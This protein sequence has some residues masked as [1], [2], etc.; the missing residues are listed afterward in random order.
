MQE[1]TLTETQHNALRFLCSD[2][3]AEKPVSA[4]VLAKKM[5][6]SW[7]KQSTKFIRSVIY[8]LQ[9]K[10]F[11]I[12]QNGKGYFYARTEKDLT[13]FLKKIEEDLLIQGKMVTGLKSSI[14]KVGYQFLGM[15]VKKDGTM[16]ADSFHLTVK[17]P[18]RTSSG[19]VAYLDLRVD[20][21]GRAILP[22]GTTLL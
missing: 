12:C 15:T 9:V 1:A 5:L 6:P 3:S 20:E 19:T 13:R 4:V 10:G 16:P 17:K 8:D 14:S 21:S 7:R 22:A 2:T 11:P 18:V